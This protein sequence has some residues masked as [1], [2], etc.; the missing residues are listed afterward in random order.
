MSFAE[1]Y[2]CDELQHLVFLRGRKKC[3]QYSYYSNTNPIGSKE[4]HLEFN[5]KLKYQNAWK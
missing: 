1:F 3:E 5:G 4:K 2:F